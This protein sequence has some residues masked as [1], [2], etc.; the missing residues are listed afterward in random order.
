MLR[1]K[2]LV[3]CFYLSWSGS[4][5][6][7]RQII[8]K[9]GSMSWLLTCSSNITLILP[10]YTDSFLKRELT[11]CNGYLSL[12]HFCSL[13]EGTFPGIEC[14]WCYAKKQ[15]ILKAQLFELAFLCKRE[16]F[17]AQPVE[18]IEKFNF[19]LNIKHRLHLSLALT[20]D[21]KWFLM[22]IQNRT[23]YFQWK[24]CLNTFLKWFHMCYFFYILAYD[25]EQF[26]RYC[27]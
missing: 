2:G 7:F 4:I 8:I 17:R 15:L 22:M 3:I 24:V 14:V 5:L 20:T 9:V 13:D 26:M 6:Q 18:S 16:D 25:F 10:L 27:I 19:R 11:F 12:L 23:F 21:Q 1:V